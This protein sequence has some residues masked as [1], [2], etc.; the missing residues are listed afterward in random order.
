[1]VVVENDIGDSFQ[2][3]NNITNQQNNRNN[4]A[5][6]N[7]KSDVSDEISNPNPTKPNIIYHQKTKK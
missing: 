1:M 5:Q 4:R 2:L 6:N 7:I 3:R